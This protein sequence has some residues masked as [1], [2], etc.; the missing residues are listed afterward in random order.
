MQNTSQNTKLYV[1][2]GF[3]LE[4]KG[5]FFASDRNPGHHAATCQKLPELKLFVAVII[6]GLRPRQYLPALRLLQNKA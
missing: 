4:R 3:N 1:K 5:F 6:Q 2:K